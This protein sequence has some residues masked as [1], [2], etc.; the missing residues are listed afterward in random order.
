M[1]RG[2]NLVGDSFGVVAVVPVHGGDAIQLLHA[3]HGAE[4]IG[5]LL[6]RLLVLLMDHQ[7]RHRL[8]HTHPPARIRTHA[9][10]YYTCAAQHRVC[11]DIRSIST[12]YTQSIRCR[13][14]G[15]DC[16]SHSV[17]GHAVHLSAVRTTGL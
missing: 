7:E 14:I 8:R 5:D 2:A 1:G 6:Q 11:M 12:R 17:C 9:C 4:V 15:V 3:E 10:P 16:K 13:G